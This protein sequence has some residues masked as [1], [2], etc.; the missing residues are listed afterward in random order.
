MSA[1]IAP[2]AAAQSSALSSGASS[3]GAT[4]ASVPS[5]TTLYGAEL[6]QAY[7]NAVAQA[8][9]DS[10]NQV[11]FRVVWNDGRPEHMIALVCAKNIFAAQLPKMPKEYIARLVLD[12]NHRTMCI[13]SPKGVIG[14]ICYRPFYSQCFAEIVFCAVTSTEQ[15][16]G[17]GTKLMNHLKEHVKRENIHYFL[18]YAD[19][20]ATGYFRKQGFTK[21]LSMPVDQW[22]GW[23][24][25]YDG[26]TL[27]E[28]KINQVVNY[29]DV[30][31]TI[32]AQ[33]EA[34]Y[35]RVK[36]V[37]HT[38]SVYPGMAFEAAGRSGYDIEEIPG[39]LEAG[40][41]REAAAALEAAAASS[42]ASSAAAPAVGGGVAAGAGAAGGAG[43]VDADGYTRLTRPE[44][45]VEVQARLGALLKSMRTLKDAWPFMQ[46]VD[47]AVVPDYYNVIREP[48]DLR[49][50]EG[51]VNAHA[52]LTLEQFEYDVMLVVNNCR[53][54][55]DR[56]TTYHK[57]ATALEEHYRETRPIYFPSVM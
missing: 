29:L 30:L 33:R 35:A 52:Y 57:C 28:C 1:A 42:A 32:A 9:K 8:H 46:P 5:V 10:R 40:W 14:G 37:S 49:T 39:V 43:A 19:N 25:D 2:A 26:G 41:T 11:E 23:I 48:M 54:Y 13:I 21:Q 56:N 16:K 20:Y 22:T 50:M 55:N 7:P 36:Q 17:Y 44:H 34:L 12:R 47:R 31:G 24:K 53:V 6:G 18:T 3:S 51:K 4:A 38:H 45:V 15:V 27:M